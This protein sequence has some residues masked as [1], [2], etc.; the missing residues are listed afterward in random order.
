MTVVM[1]AAI[2]VL[3]VAALLATALL[4][5]LPRLERRGQGNQAA[6]RPRSGGPRREHR[7]GRL[8]V[9]VLPADPD[10]QALLPEPVSGG[11]DRLPDEG[12]EIDVDHRGPGGVRS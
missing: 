6:H 3:T 7:P 4:A 12:T 10:H 5:V 1:A 9:A 8:P 11:A 2:A